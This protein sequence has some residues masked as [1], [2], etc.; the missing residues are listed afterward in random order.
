MGQFV[1]RSPRGKHASENRTHQY[2]ELKLQEEMIL[3]PSPSP[4]KPGIIAV[5]TSELHIDI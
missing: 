1:F 3:S 2:A 5:A 4:A